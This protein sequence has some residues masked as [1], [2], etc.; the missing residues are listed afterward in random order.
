M[1]CKKYEENDVLLK[2]S[3]DTSICTVLIGLNTIKDNIALYS[4]VIESIT[5]TEFFNSLEYDNGKLSSINYSF[6]KD[7]FPK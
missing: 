6:E 5:P 3:I 7:A 4:N 1:F 2:K